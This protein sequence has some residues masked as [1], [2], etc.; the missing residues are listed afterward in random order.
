MRFDFVIM[1]N[2]KPSTII[3]VD[4]EFHFSRNGRSLSQFHYSLEADV[5][6][7]GFCLRNKIPLYRIP[8][9]E[10]KHL[11]KYKD[12]FQKEFKVYDKF[13]NHYIIQRRERGQG[14]K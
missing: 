3:E 6:K 11:R 8:F 13:H 2:G 5:Q 7:N 12:L 4:G 9:Y 14:K 1:K 10:V